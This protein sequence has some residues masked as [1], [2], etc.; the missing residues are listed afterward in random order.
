MPHELEIDGDRFRD[1]D[2]FVAEFN[3]AYLAVFG[4]RPWDGADFNDLDTFLEAPGERLTIR[5]RDS[6]RS[7]SDLGHDAMARFWSRS[8]A[9][10]RT[11][12]PHQAAIHRDYQEKIDDAAA[13]RGPTLFDWLVE[14]LDHEEYV[15]LI[16][17]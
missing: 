16:L 5:W 2:G 10:C 1:Y 15:E 4:G 12:F 3:R 17:E 6:A 7:R 8:L 11:E 14:Q 9:S 13:G